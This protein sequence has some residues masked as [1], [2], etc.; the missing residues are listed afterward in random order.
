MNHEVPDFSSTPMTPKPEQRGDFVAKLYQSPDL[1]EFQ[2]NERVMHALRAWKTVNRR[3]RILLRG[4]RQALGTSTYIIDIRD[5]DLEEIGSLAALPTP[6]VG[7]VM[8][9]E[10]NPDQDEEPFELPEAAMEVQEMKDSFEEARVQANMEPEHVVA[11]S[12][13][14]GYEGMVGPVSPAGFLTLLWFIGRNMIDVRTC[15]NR[16][17]R[18]ATGGTESMI[19]QILGP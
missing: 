7:E 10:I 9:L 13:F 1:T 8:L 15:M 4:G 18:R 16:Y 12:Y 6:N 17:Y 3:T 5:L 2:F 11:Y 19:H 14:L